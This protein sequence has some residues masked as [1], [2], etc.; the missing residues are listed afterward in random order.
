MYKKYVVNFNQE[1]IA[2][3]NQVIELID[4]ELERLK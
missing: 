4:K 2:E 1:A 3:T